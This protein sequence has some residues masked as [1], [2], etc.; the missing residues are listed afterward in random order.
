MKSSPKQQS[1]SSPI[2]IVFIDD[3]TLFRHT[4]SHVLNEEP[5]IKVVGEAA[6]RD[7]GLAMITRL[8]PDILIQDIN[9]GTDDGLE[10][11]HEIRTLSPQLKCL[12]LTGMVENALILRAIRKRADGYLL[13]DCAIPAVIEAIRKLARGQKVWD[14]SLIARLADLDPD[15]AR[16]GGPAGMENLN[17]TEQRIAQ[18]IAEGHTNRQIGQQL[19]LAEKTIRNRI[20]LILD[21][22]QVPRRSC[23]A[24]LYARCAERNR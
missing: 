3:H 8:N 10:V 5:D 20:S 23:I 2:R 18:L 19:H 14:P 16:D 6:G 1:P 7:E 12:I 11:M 9:L 15:P 17:T 21:K 24:S 22:L 13:K 4:L